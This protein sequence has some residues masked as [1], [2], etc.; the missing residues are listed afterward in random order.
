[1]TSSARSSSSHEALGN[2]RAPM[3]SAPLDRL[4]AERQAERLP[5]RRGGRRSRRSSSSGR[6]LSAQPSYEDEHAATADTQYRIGSITKTFTATAIMQLRAAGKLDLDDRL[7]QHLDG[8]R[9]RLADDPAAPLPPVGPAARGGGDVRHRRT[10]RPR[11][12]WWTPQ[13]VSFVLPP[14]A[15]APLLEPRV[16]AARPGRRPRQAGRRTPTTS[17]S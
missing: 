1:M 13:S 2:V 8:S 10:R 4:L 16:R 11:S 17:T 5:S 9:D 12:S 3:R 14:G 6:A 7:E 15:A